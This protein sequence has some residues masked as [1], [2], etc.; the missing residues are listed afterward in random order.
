MFLHSRKIILYKKK[1]SKIEHSK[2]VCLWE[3]PTLTTVSIGQKLCHLKCYRYSFGAAW[4]VVCHV[5]TKLEECTNRSY[6]N[7]PIRRM[8]RFL[9]RWQH[10]GVNARQQH[11]AKHQLQSLFPFNSTRSAIS[12]VFLP[13]PK[14]IPND[15]LN[16]LVYVCSGLG[17]LPI[18]FHRQDGGLQKHDFDLSDNMPVKKAAKTHGRR[19]PVWTQC[20]WCCGLK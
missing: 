11:W 10:C 2:G 5:Y 16:S 7:F 12:T 19:S 4:L 3:Q 20:D 17:M 9:S 14:I 15:L 13:Y 8:L 6:N 18:R 1:R